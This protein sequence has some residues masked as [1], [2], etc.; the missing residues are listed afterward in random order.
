MAADPSPAPTSLSFPRST[1]A[2]L[3][4]GP[5]LHAHLKQNPPIR[6]SGRTLT[7][8]RE[9]QITTGSLTHSHGSAVVRLGDTT[10]VCSVQG[11]ILKA[12]DIP[13]PPDE[14]ADNEDLLET[15]GLLV[16]NIE[17][18]TGCSPAHLPG[19]PPSTLAQSL[20]WKVRTLL[21]GSEIVNPEDL[22]IMFTAP[23]IDEEDDAPV[24]EVK[25][26]WTLYLDIMFISLDGNPFDAA[27]LAVMAALRTTR[28]PRASWDADR[29][30]VVCSPALE[31]YAHLTLHTTP[32]TATFAVFSTAN[33]L[34]QR[35][36]AESW[37]LTDPDTSEEEVC[38][39]ALTVTVDGKRVLG[40][41]KAGGRVIGMEAVEECVKLTFARWKE[42]STIL[43]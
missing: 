9:Q 30:A 28:L 39:E 37:V 8:F 22:Q 23:K 16:P 27:W 35:S 14:S 31:H 10:V 6:P 24:P 1:F 13:S 36:E 17:L 42:V 19:N 11:E 32:V 29:E 15:L 38:R 21:Y 7:Q 41:D 20:S 25:A 18:S 12:A 2:K 26:Y 4:P 40:I 34:K 33:P 3:T 43:P 5:F